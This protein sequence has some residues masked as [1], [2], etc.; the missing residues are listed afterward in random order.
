MLILGQLNW[1]TICKPTE[2]S[3]ISLLGKYWLGCSNETLSYGTFFDAPAPQWKE[4]DLGRP[5]LSVAQRNQS[6]WHIG[7]MR[8]IGFMILGSQN[9]RRAL[10]ISGPFSLVFRETKQSRTRPDS[11]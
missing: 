3:L 6:Q 2:H 1:K 8:D 4:L 7:T 10:A 11:K 9:S 5:I